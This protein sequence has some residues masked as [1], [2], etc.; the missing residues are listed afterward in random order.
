MPLIGYLSVGFPEQDNIP[1]RL[2][3]FRQGLN[4]AG[5]VDGRNVVIEYRGA[6]RPPA[7]PGG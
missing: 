7:G 1:G 2:G 6:K 3:A 4:E 5:Y